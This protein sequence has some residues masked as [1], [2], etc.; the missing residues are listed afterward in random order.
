ME[1]TPSWRRIDT[2]SAHGTFVWMRLHTRVC[3]RDADM[4]QNDR[5][6]GGCGAAGCTGSVFL[7]LCV[8]LGLSY[9]GADAHRES[10]P[11]CPPSS[12]HA[13][14]LSQS[15]QFRYTFVISDD[16]YAPLPGASYLLVH[17]SFPFAF[18]RRLCGPAF[19]PLLRL[20]CARSQAAS[21]PWAACCSLRT[22]EMCCRAYSPLLFFLLF[23]FVRESSANAGCNGEAR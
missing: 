22:V 21:R 20:S 23:T 16:K 5:A 17:L 18:L 10:L 9:I 11:S 12:P 14:T 7:R 2:A 13:L 3:C 6:S 1:G 15:S 4:Y 8:N 19:A